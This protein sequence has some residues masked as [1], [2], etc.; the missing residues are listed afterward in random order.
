MT[1]VYGVDAML[2]LLPKNER[3]TEK[4]VEKLREPLISQSAGRD[5]PTGRDQTDRNLRPRG[6]L[7]LKSHKSQ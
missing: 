2:A 5:R 3:L 4:H 1:T 6:R 7:G